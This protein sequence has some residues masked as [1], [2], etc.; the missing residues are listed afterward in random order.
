MKITKCIVAC[1]LNEMYYSFYPLVRKYW[2]N[3]VGIDTLLILIGDFI[4]D[5]LQ[6][7][8]DEIILFTPIPYI[9]NAFQAQCIRV[10]YPSLL[11]DNEYIIISDMD[12]IPLNKK[13]YVD[14]VKDFKDDNFVIYRNVISDCNQYP[15]CFCL[16][17][18]KTWKNIFNINNVDDIIKTIT[19]W[20]SLY[21]NYELS[22]PFSL[23]WACDQLEL[24][25][26]VNNW[27]HQDKVIKLIDKETDFKRLDRSEVNNIQY[28][29]SHYKNLIENQYFSDFHLPRPLSVYQELLN[30]ILI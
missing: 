15:I 12:L 7:Y 16:A 21:D 20:F 23:A 4:P 11:P 25:Q 14:N 27:K 17:N 2:K 18:S 9:H 22:S 19:K 6:I 5:S 8:K 24:F 13:Y 30:K 3:I 29:T 1:D 26:H 28:N 10:L